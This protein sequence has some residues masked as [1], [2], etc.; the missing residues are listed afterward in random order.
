[1]ADGG[2]E[3]AGACSTGKPGLQRMVPRVFLVSAKEVVNVL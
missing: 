2:R 1:M 3:V